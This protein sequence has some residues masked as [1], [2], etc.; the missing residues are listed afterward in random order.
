MI[1]RSR[2]ADLS[3]C[4]GCVFWFM[5]ILA[6]HALGS[7]RQPV[8]SIIPRLML[9][10]RSGAWG[11]VC[12]ARDHTSLLVRELHLVSMWSMLSSV[13]QIA[14]VCLPSAPGMRLHAAPT[15]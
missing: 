5:A 11:H 7:D 13:L 3:L 14:H 15:M 12:R 6:L 10:Q 2:R 4:M 1:C 8:P 9:G